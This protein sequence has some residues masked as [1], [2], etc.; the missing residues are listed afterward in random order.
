M[1]LND[2][3][4][5]LLSVAVKTFVKHFLDALPANMLL[6]QPTKL[7]LSSYQSYNGSFPSKDPE[8]QGDILQT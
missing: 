7:T 5:Y 2:R 8:G 3:S 6:V 4:E 1:R